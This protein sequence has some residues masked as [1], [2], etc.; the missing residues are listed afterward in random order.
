MIRHCLPLHARG[1]ESRFRFA[2]QDT[3][4]ADGHLAERRDNI[5]RS[6]FQNGA[7][8]GGRLAFLAIEFVIDGQGFLHAFERIRKRFRHVHANRQLIASH[9][10]A[11]G[12][13]NVNPRA[14]R[15]VARAQD[16]KDVGFVLGP[17]HSGQRLQHPVE[18]RAA[19]IEMPQARHIVAAGAFQK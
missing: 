19:L 15:A 4:L 2:N 13:N 11:H 12:V 6:N 7:I 1:G 17:G 14:V 10:G 3:P 9:G 18:R 16:V 8:Q 5:F